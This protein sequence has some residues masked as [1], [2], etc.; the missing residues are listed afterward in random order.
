MLPLRVD[1]RDQLPE[2]GVG[3]R[4]PL[5]GKIRGVIAVKC[6]MHKAGSGV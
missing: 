4:K 1:F 6:F 3:P 2:K 5:A